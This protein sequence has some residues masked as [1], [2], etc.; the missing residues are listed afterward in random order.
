[1][2]ALGL[3]ERGFYSFDVNAR[4]RYTEGKEPLGSGDWWKLLWFCWAKK[5]AGMVFVPWRWWGG[6]ESTGTWWTPPD[7]ALPSWSF[8]LTSIF[9]AELNFWSLWFFSSENINGEGKARFLQS[10]QAMVRRKTAKSFSSVTGG[11]GAKWIHGQR[12][13]DVLSL[14]WSLPGLLGVLSPCLCFSQSFLQ[15]RHDSC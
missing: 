8:I 6:G 11:M 14:T 10:L 5:A 4:E 1:V 7:K 2:R 15:P 12:H 9:K 3:G 13:V